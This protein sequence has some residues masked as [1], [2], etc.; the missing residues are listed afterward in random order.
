MRGIR[1]PMADWDVT[2]LLL[3]NIEFGIR[4]LQWQNAG[5]GQR[6]SPIP[7]PDGDRPGPA[8]PAGVDVAHRLAALGLIP[9]DAVSD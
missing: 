5:K 6:P 7:L 1:G 8:R 3:R 2:A 9:T 4:G